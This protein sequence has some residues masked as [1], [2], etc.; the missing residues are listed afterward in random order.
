[1]SKTRLSVFFSGT[2]MTWE[3]MALFLELNIQKRHNLEKDKSKHFFYLFDGPA[4]AMSDQHKPVEQIH[5]DKKQDDLMSAR[6]RKMENSVGNAYRWANGSGMTNITDSAYQLILHSI[7]AN[8]VREIDLIGFS[9]GGCI[10]LDVGAILSKLEKDLKDK[11]PADDLKQIAVNIYAVDPVAGKSNNFKSHQLGAISHFVKKCVVGLATNESVP[12][13]HPR[14]ILCPA[15]RYNIKFNPTTKY[16]F[17][18]FPEDHAMSLLWMKDIIRSQLPADSE[19]LSPCDEK[20]LIERRLGTREVKWAGGQADETRAYRL[21]HYQQNKAVFS[22]SLF[23]AEYKTDQFA[24]KHAIENFFKFLA[25][26]HS[27][28]NIGHISLQNAADAEEKNRHYTGKKIGGA[29]PVT[30]TTQVTYAK[31][32]HSLFSRAIG[33]SDRACKRKMSE[34]T[35]RLFVN[36]LHEA[37]FTQIYPALHQLL[38][39][40]SAKDINSALQE[41]E[42]ISEQQLPFTKAYIENALMT[43]RDMSLKPLDQFKSTNIKKYD[44]LLELIFPNIKLEKPVISSSSKDLENDDCR[45]LQLK[46]L[47]ADSTVSEEKRPSFNLT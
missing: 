6:T 15:Y 40:H 21:I 33:F 27:I 41:F 2:H 37:L 34:Y 5:F 32:N 30:L 31:R 14:D 13:F 46:K 38:L 7:Q 16:V 45:I 24:M 26:E 36:L 1:M 42:H 44:E 39:Y 3:D 22:R 11:L 8:S 47:L 20:R 17:L 10:A 19:L 18:T 23:P 29:R 25:T 12:G 43:M 35:N 4:A 28:Y 9:R